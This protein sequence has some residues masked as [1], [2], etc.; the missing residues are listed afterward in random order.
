MHQKGKASDIWA[1]GLILLEMMVG[2]PVWDLGFDFGIKA[3]EEPHFIYDYINDNV[4]A[5]FNAKL[6]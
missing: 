1:L 5:K 3:I 4:P 6:K 2:C